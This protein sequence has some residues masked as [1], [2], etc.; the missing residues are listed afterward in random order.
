MIKELIERI[1]LEL[2]EIPRVLRRMDDGWAR[3]R[4]SRDDLYLDGVALNV[5]GFYM[6]LNAF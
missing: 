5:H 2:E 1:H 3:A 4:S 6:G